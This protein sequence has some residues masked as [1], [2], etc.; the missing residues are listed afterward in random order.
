M[1][2]YT[3]CTWSFFHCNFG[4][5]QL[6]EIILLLLTDPQMCV[7]FCS[8]LHWIAVGSDGGAAAQQLMAYEHGKDLGTRPANCP[9]L[10]AHLQRCGGSEAKQEAR[11][12]D[13][14]H[15]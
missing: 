5:F 3:L 10:W 15:A 2:R 12:V 4:I 7:W 13:R 9:G 1:A 6:L 8:L 14:D 11:S